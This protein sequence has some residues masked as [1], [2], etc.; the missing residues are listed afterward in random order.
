[1]KLFLRI[2]IIFFGV[3]SVAA[4]LVSLLLI[5]DLGIQSPGDNSHPLEYH[6]AL[7]LPDNQN[8][9]F[10]DVIRGAEQAAAELNASISLHSINPMKQELE[11]ASYAGIDGALVC[12]Y[13]D[14]AL[15]RR[16]LEKLRAEN[17]P[18]VLIN[19][20]VMNDQPWPF[21]GTNNFDIGRRMGMIARN[22][23]AS[24]LNN[25]Q[26]RPVLVFSEKSPGI[27][28]ERE[29]VEMGIAASLGDRLASPIITMR[30]TLNP[31][32]AE[33][34][35]NGLFRST[36]EINTIIF[37]DSSDTIAAAHALIDMNLVGQV[38]VIGFGNDP[39]ILENIR[40]G[41]IAGS[42]V[43]NSERMGYEA[44]QSLISLRSSGYTSTSIDTGVTIVDRNTL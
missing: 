17:I 13:L 5:Q 37:T 38:Q 18:V 41:I 26:V 32:D 43:V 23:I 30:T 44:V 7:Y 20:N 28:S 10:A 39:V 12:P 3:L 27:Y 11:M 19:H 8:S 36:T 34:I 22:T 24:D 25:G 14:D 21:I 6:I 29:L 31:L 9:F 1:M 16:Q 35:I 42:I 15:A 2:S 33:E 40:K 4:F